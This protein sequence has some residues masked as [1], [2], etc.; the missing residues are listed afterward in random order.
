MPIMFSGF[1]PGPENATAVGYSNEFNG[2]YAQLMRLFT[3]M[4][5]TVPN[6]LPVTQA[7]LTEPMA[8]GLHAVTKANLA[9]GESV[10]VHGC[11]PV[12]L[13]IIASLRLL[14]DRHIVASDF[15]PKRRALAAQLG[16]TA[17]VDPAADDVWDVWQRDAGSTTVVQFD[18]IGVQ[19]ILNRIMQRAPR[20]SRVVV[21]GVCMEPDTITPIWGINKEL[22]LQFVLGY[23]P[24][25]FAATLGHLSEGRLDGSALITGCV[26]LE[27]VSA[28]F[29]AL[30]NPEDNVKILVEPNGPN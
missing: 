4:L 27:Q 24:Q 19:G 11:G 9:D 20:H 8:V 1:P 22:N 5:L 12:G 14:G 18:A 2:G 26:P 23:T 21:V 29:A 6:G 28:A 7:A 30:G 17:V 25:E 3:P 10:I 16:A 15:S 13:A